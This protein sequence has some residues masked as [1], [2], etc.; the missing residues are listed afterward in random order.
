MDYD[1]S[2]S[3]QARCLRIRMT[4]LLRWEGDRW[5]IVHEH[6]FQPLPTPKARGWVARGCHLLAMTTQTG[7]P[8]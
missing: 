4:W 1:V 2:G 8:A 5:R 6:G 7:L 3:G